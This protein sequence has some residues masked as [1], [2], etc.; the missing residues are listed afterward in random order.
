MKNG[1]RF[2]KRR[3]KEWRIR[4]DWMAHLFLFC[5]STKE[6]ETQVKKGSF[7]SSKKMR[8]S[9]PPWILG[10]RQ[11]TRKEDTK[12]KT[13]A[14]VSMPGYLAPVQIKASL[15][16]VERFYLKN[17]NS[18]SISEWW[19]LPFLSNGATFSCGITSSSASKDTTRMKKNGDWSKRYSDLALSSRGSSVGGPFCLLIW[20]R[21]WGWSRI[22]LFSSK[23][24]F[25]VH[26]APAYSIGAC[27]RHL[28]KSKAVC[29]S[30]PPSGFFC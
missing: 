21:G 11:A 12:Y 13:D 1:K 26:L 16:T 10:V 14:V 24:K 29:C 7:M 2:G 8:E 18:G 30:S 28:M 19:S 3:R 5:I 15:G 22:F 23:Q 9:W 17:R 25:R 4:E 6:R 27:L 20:C